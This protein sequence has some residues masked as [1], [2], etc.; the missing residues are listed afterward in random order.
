ML[1]N[2]Y[3]LFVCQISKNVED[4]IILNLPCHLQFSC[5]LHYTV[6]KIEVYT[7]KRNNKSKM[8]PLFQENFE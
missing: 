6:G 5:G 3:Y 8:D 7:I 4:K 1:I 2:K